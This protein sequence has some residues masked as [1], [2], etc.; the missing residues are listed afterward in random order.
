MSIANDT[1]WASGDVLELL[2]GRLVCEGCAFCELGYNDETDVSGCPTVVRHCIFE[3][4]DST[5]FVRRYA[6]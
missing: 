5:K 6:A 3:L 1:R 4:L 2:V